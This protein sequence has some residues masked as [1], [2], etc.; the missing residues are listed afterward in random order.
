MNITS[1]K[2]VLV[3]GLVFTFDDMYIIIRD[4]LFCR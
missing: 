4:L 1:D 3:I 2:A